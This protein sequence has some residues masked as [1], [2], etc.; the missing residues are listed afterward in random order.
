MGGTHIHRK[1]AGQAPAGSPRD[2]GDQALA[3]AFRGL[4]DD[5]WQPGDGPVSQGIM[6]WV[7]DGCPSSQRARL[8]RQPVTPDP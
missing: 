4:G 7:V 2:I 8:A 6:Q 3:E 1:A 5:L